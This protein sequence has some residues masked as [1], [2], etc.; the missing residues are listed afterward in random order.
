MDKNV[1]YQIKSLKN[2]FKQFLITNL[3]NENRKT[4]YFKNIFPNNN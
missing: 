4:K 2:N 3:L 1:K